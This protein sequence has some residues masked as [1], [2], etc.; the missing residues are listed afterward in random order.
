ML[1]KLFFGLYCR[2]VKSNSSCT[3]STAYFN[4]ILQEVCIFVL[5]IPC[6]LFTKNSFKEGP[7][8]FLFV[9]LPFNMRIDF[10]PWTVN[11]PF[12]QKRYCTTVTIHTSII[13]LINAWVPIIIQMLCIILHSVS[14]TEDIMSSFSIILS[15]ILCQ[16]CSS[17]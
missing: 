17:H 4:R 6:P 10:C 9:F 8:K 2:F 14:P 16:M 12:L 11:L 13:T 7:A 1:R 3:C 5:S 15:Q